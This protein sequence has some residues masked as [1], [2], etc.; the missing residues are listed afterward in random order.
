LVDW[1]DGSSGPGTVANGECQASHAYAAAGSP[2]IR[3]TATDD[4]TAT[5]ADEVAIV[6]G[7][8]SGDG[9]VNGGGWIAPNGVRTNF[10]GHAEAVG[11]SA[12]GEI[13]V[14]W[15][16]HRFHAHEVAS[17]AVTG[18]KAT[19]NGQGDFDGTP[20]YAYVIAVDDHR[21]GNGN[22][23]KPTPDTFSIEIR[24]PSGAV[25]FSAAGPLKG[26]NIEVH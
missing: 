13:E 5:G 16:K 25:V 11:G 3:V 6:V 23:K 7:S 1:G 24:D 26:G 14:N 10:G 15:A 21:N 20:G 4:D 9:K 19:W 12:T 18:S 22:G 2:T 8:P 17:L